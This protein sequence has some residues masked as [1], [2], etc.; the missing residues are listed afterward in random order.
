MLTNGGKLGAKKGLDK[1]FSS[2]SL[3]KNKD[4]GKILKIGIDFLSYSRYN[5]KLRKSE[6]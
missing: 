6:Y 4:F 3:E 1:K 2:V 5:V